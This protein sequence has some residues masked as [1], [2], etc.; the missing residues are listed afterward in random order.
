MNVYQYN[1]I[2]RFGECDPAG[3]VYYPVFFNWFHETMEA[4]FE[5]GLHEPYAKVIQTFGFPAKKISAEFHRP[6]KM[7]EALT[8]ELTVAELGRSSLRLA[9]VVKGVDGKSKATGD[10]LCVCIGVAAGEFQFR[11]HPIP[12][13]LRQKMSQFTVQK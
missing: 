13:E 7:G 8:I 3:V 9:I 4:W 2:V 5:S 1:R 10:V 6:C 11:S 12:E